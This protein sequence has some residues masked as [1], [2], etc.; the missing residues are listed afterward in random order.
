MRTDQ[1]GASFAHAELFIT[2]LLGVHGLALFNTLPVERSSCGV[3]THCAYHFVTRHYARHSFSG[4][5]LS[6]GAEAGYKENPMLSILASRAS[7]LKTAVSDVCTP[8]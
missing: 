8:R 5:A 1:R 3:G 4:P 6:F 7:G 2:S